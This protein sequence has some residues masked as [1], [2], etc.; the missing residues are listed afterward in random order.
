MPFESSG[1]PCDK[2]TRI[3]RRERSPHKSEI[4]LGRL[5]CRRKPHDQVIATAFLFKDALAAIVL[6]V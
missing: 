5:L 3:T 4:D 1:L 2:L 6:A